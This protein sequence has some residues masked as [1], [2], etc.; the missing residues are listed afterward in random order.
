MILIVITI[1]FF[2]SENQILHEINFSSHIHLL[3]S[4]FEE[5]KL[6]FEFAL[7]AFVFP[8]FWGD[9]SLVFFFFFS[10]LALT[11]YAGLHVIVI[12]YEKVIT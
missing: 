2:L 10:W 6:F 8:S 9:I 11:V 5:T 12:S 7:F 3:Q 1:F 4:V